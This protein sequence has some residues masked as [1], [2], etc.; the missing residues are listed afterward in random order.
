M[1]ELPPGV[2]ALLAPGGPVAVGFDAA[3]PLA[4]SSVDG[5]SWVR[6]SGIDPA[7]GRMLAVAAR[8]FRGVAVG[9]GP[10]GGRA[11]GP[12]GGRAGA[13]APRAG[14]SFLESPPTATGLASVAAGFKITAAVSLK[15][16]IRRM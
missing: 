11:W 8:P 15:V 2:D 6:I 1:V 7:G 4:W 9:A 10:A 5:R 16:S 13:P 14:A 3:G 12:G